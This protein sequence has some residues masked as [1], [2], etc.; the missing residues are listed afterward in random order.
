MPLAGMWSM[1]HGVWLGEA[2]GR[3]GR[4]QGILRMLRIVPLVNT[5]SRIYT[6]PTL[7]T[8]VR[9]AALIKA[10]SK[11]SGRKDFRNFI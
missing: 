8:E 9:G 10:T 4:D 2:H 5:G 11:T 6:Q 1:S 7:R 3:L